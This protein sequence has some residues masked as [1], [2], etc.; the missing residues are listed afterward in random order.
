[1]FRLTKAQL[2]WFDDKARK[3]FVE[4]ISGY[5]EQNFRDSVSGLSKD[6]LRAWVDGGVERALRFHIVDEPE[7]AQLILLHLVLG[8]SADETT[9]WVKETLE[10]EGLYPAGKLNKLIEQARERRVESIEQVVTERFARP[11]GLEAIPW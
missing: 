11:F 10:D 9:P 6:E 3:D 8:Q 5:L 7:V 1:M 4:R 2:G